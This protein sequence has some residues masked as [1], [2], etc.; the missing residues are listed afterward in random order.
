MPTLEITMAAVATAVPRMPKSRAAPERH[1]GVGARRGGLEAPEEPER[2][3]D[4][5]P[6]PA[7]VGGGREPR[8]PAPGQDRDPHEPCQQGLG[9]EAVPAVEP[10]PRDDEERRGDARR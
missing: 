10:A 6:Q 2:E 4:E 5:Q 8:P 7:Q 9:E 3:S 1:H